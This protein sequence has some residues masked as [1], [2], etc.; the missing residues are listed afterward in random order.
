MAQTFDSRRLRHQRSMARRLTTEHRTLARII[1][2]VVMRFANSRSVDGERVIPNRRTTRDTVKAAVWS[3]V[4]K[5]YYIGAGADPLR[6]ATPLSPFARLLVDGITEATRIQA[7]RQVALV[8]RLVRDAEVLAWLTGPRPLNAGVREL[9]GVYDPFHQ[10]VDPNGYRL[11]DRI[12]RTGIETRSH[13]DQL[14]D[15]HI[16]QGTAAVRMAELLEEFLAPG[17]GNQRTVRPYGRDGSY[18][19]RRLARTE[20]TAAAGRG[21]INASAANPFVG[22][23]QW[24]L[25]GSHPKIDVCDSYARGGENGDG[26]YTLETVPRYPPHPNCLCSL[27]PVPM[28]NVS[29]L[30]AG[31][32]QEIRARTQRAVALQ[33]MLNATWLTQAIL[34]GFLD[35]AVEA[36]P[37]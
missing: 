2:V 32:R 13:V 27:L 21:V 35:E 11:S 8:R 22:G 15:Y 24:R 17:A 16:G 9:R 25:S 3:E 30:V 33:G 28:G 1:A 36:I 14:L 26:I 31:L 7:E 4:L 18:A 37:G 29:D 23:V 6:G 12:W 19:A 5:P 10:W 34:D 20:I